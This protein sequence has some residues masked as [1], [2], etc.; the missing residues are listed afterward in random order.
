MDGPPESRTAPEAPTSEAEKAEVPGGVSSGKGTTK[1]RDDY[2]RERYRVDGAIK[3]LLK[4][5]AKRI[6]PNKFPWNIHR[7]TA[8]TW[9]KVRLDVSLVKPVGRDSYH[10]KGLA[11]C[12][13]V[14]TCP[15]CASKIQERRREEVGQAIAHWDGTGKLP[16]MV[17]YT[18]PHR[19]DQ[20]LS[21]LLRLQQQAIK[22]M[23]EGRAYKALMA[24]LSCG[25]RIRSLEVTHGENGWHP[26][27]HELL[28]V[29]TTLDVAEIRH[30]LSV[31]WIKSCTKVGLFNPEVH[32]SAAFYRHGVDAR[33]GDGGAAAYLAKMDDQT[34]WNLSHEVTKSSSKQGRRSGLH[35]FR[36][37]DE[38]PEKFIEY[39]HAMKGQLQLVWSRGLKADVGIEEKTDEQVAEEETSRVEDQIDLPSNSWRVVLANDARFEVVD[40]AKREGAVGVAKLLEQ[41]GFDHAQANTRRDAPVLH[42]RGGQQS[43]GLRW[44]LERLENARALSHLSVQRAGRAASTRSDSVEAGSR[45]EGAT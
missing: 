2:L 35:P 38:N 8:C 9:A 6:D 22:T 10:Y 37:V 32:D 36:L 28:G 33:S 1:S 40:A 21:L 13:S 17:S 43:S 45:K 42:Q 3:R 18:F 23:R 30:Q 11:T 44:G 5:D 19:V 20:P 27:T 24:R 7:Q 29:D 16:L 15:I 14:W 34:K 31:L 12:G 25:G 41:L 39:V 26:H 4:L